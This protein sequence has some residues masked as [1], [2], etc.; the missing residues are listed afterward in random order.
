[1]GVEVSDEGNSLIVYETRFS[2]MSEVAVAAFES[3]LVE[4]H[5]CTVNP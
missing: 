1:M 2:G 4:M 3:A 5:D